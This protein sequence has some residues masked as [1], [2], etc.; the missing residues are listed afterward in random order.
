MWY[1]C[2]KCKKPASK[3]GCD[4]FLLQDNV[5]VCWQCYQEWAQGVKTDSISDKK[6]TARNTKYETIFKQIKQA[7]SQLYEKGN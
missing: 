3:G 1:R 5:H 7:F 6:R 2:A 4:Y